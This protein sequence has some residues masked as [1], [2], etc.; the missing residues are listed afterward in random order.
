MIAEGSPAEARAL[1]N[2]PVSRRSFLAVAVVAGGA[3]AVSGGAG[4][5]ILR[6]RAVV[7]A[8]S[9]SSLRIPAP[10]FP[11]PPMNP[12]WDLNIP[13]LTS[14]F[15]PTA[16]FYR[17]DTELV[18]PQVDVKT[19]RLRIHG[20]VDKE[21][22]LT[23][24]ELV[25]RPLV[26]CDI[27]LSCVSNEVGGRYASNGR[28]IGVPLK[29]LLEEA[30]VKAGA[31]QVVSR[32]VDGWTSGTPTADLMDGRNAILAVALNGKPLPAEHGYPVRMLVPGVY[33]YANATKWI[34]DIE[35]STFAAYKAYW[36]AHGYSQNPPPIK[37]LSR[38]DTPAPLANIKPG[39]TPIAGIAWA[40][41]RGI[42]KVEV[43]VDNGPWQV[44]RLSEQDNI[45]TWRQFV[46]M[47]DAT[48]G[49]H[50]L[51]CR[52][53]DGIGMLQTSLRTPS[54]PDG[55][56]GWDSVVVTVMNS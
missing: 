55:A 46:V 40:Q 44:A 7:S 37:T 52:A 43:S 54:L 49:Q 45:D 36:A 29:A 3:A 21:I 42:Q 23:F 18:V 30:G 27:T 5:G 2:R 13:G 51:Q 15:T 22:N 12:A 28:W 41:H 6:H 1:G 33:G 32:S 10:A 39:M 47:W 31:D 24:D 11:A 9:A 19:W 35:L 14:F 20:M 34:V 48:P 56:T 38:I 17:V 50:S 25:A 53:T 4:Y 8:A 16:Q 26:E